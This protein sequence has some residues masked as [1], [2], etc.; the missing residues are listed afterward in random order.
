MRRRVRGDRRQAVRRIDGIVEVAQVV[1]QPA[2][3]RV[4]VRVLEPWQE[5]FAVELD[6]L[7][8]PADER[9]N[10][11]VAADRDDPA[12]RDGD[13]LGGSRQRDERLDGRAQEDEIRLGG[14]HEKTPCA[15]RRAGSRRAGWLA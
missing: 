7:G 2:L 4:D 6:D 5:G 3:D 8:P 10:L 1:E 13:R 15:H 14:G 11:R 9:A 12:T